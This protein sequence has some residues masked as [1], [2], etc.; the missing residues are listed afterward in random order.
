MSDYLPGK[1]ADLLT[2]ALNFS[3]LLTAAPAQYGLTANDAQTVAAAVQAFQSAYTTAS[4]PAT[5]TP[6]AIEDKNDA[7]EAMVDVLRG[8]AVLIKSNRAVAD[9]EKVA[10]GLGVADTEPTPVQAPAKAPLIIEILRDAARR[11]TLKFRDADAPDRRAKPA[12][13]IGLQIFCHVGDAPPDNPENSRFKSFC[14]RD[15]FTMN[16]DAPDVGKTAHYW[17]RWQ[18]RTGKT[19]PF[20]DMQSAPVPA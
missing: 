16:F 6:V 17:A 1:E 13:A 4:N 10:L 3:T 14:S 11:H 8:F 7:K 19:S 12:G 9:G 18:T 15:A 5:R 20:S 2:W